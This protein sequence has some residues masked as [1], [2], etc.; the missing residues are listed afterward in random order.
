M[1]RVRVPLMALIAI[2]P[3]EISL[4]AQAPDARSSPQTRRRLRYSNDSMPAPTGALA[5]VQQWGYG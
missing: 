4:L 2:A 5:G 3:A 1:F